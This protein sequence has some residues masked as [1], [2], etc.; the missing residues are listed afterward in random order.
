MIS[1]DWL[2]GMLVHVICWGGRSTTWILPK[3]DACLGTRCWWTIA[4]E[5]WG[6]G[7]NGWRGWFLH[8]IQN[9]NTF[10][11]HK[12]LRY[13]IFTGPIKFISQITYSELYG[14][15][16]NQIGLILGLFRMSDMRFKSICNWIKW[17]IRTVNHPIMLTMLFGGVPWLFSAS[18]LF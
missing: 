5:L 14:S 16:S 7:V 12:S 4:N 9:A 2:P 15:F 1:G 18:H 13:F 3:G 6:W 17:M 10:V 8:R 11:K